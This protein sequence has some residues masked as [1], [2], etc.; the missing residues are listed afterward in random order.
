M[1]RLIISSIATFR[2]ISLLVAHE[3]E[4]IQRVV[5]DGSDGHAH[6]VQLYRFPSESA[7]DGFLADP[8][9]Q[10]LSAERD[11]VIALTQLFPVHA[12]TYCARCSPVSVDFAATRSEGT[13]SN[14]TRPPS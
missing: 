12:P 6:E 7:L 1:W 10:D 3:A 14:T 5:S 13:P 8:R 9:R 2:V 11:R 4:I